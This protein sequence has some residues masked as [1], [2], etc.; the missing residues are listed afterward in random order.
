M[1]DYTAPNGDPFTYPPIAAVLLSPLAWVPPPV[2]ELAWFLAEVAVMAWLAVAVANRRYPR[3]RFARAAP[4]IALLLAVSAPM[5]S[6]VEFGQL[7]IFVLAAAA[8]TVFGLA[9][10]LPLGA[11]A[12]VK[13]LPGGAVPVLFA[14]GRRREATWAVAA[15]VALTIAGWVLL[16]EESARFWLHELPSGAGYGDVSLPGN[17]S[18]M[19]VLSR[20]GL[21]QEPARWWW[22]VLVA[23][24]VAWAVRSARRVQAKLGLESLLLVAALI[25]LV[26]PVSWTHHQ[27]LL[28]LAALLRVSPDRCRQ[29]MWSGS[30]VVVMSV[31]LWNV[32]L[33]GPLGWVLANSRFL[34]AVL[35]LFVV[36]GVS[37]APTT[38]PED[39]RPVIDL[40]PAPDPDVH[41]V[42]AV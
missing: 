24:A 1:Y 30:V 38:R 22:L 5:G 39:Q 29:A 14:Q 21:G 15:C 28:A 2:I 40:G 10:G 4:T 36:P 18:V 41:P 20:F 37:K 8:A 11:A 19:G 27:L 13:L 32:G 3:D 25:V 7:S 16:P 23:A 9:G 33:P 31:N 35:T 34:L 26:A 42:D 17:Q 12:A 6:M